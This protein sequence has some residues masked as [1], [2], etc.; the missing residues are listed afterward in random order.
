MA[1]SAARTFLRVPLQTQPPFALARWLNE[2]SPLS[3]LSADV[4]ALAE[5]ALADAEAIASL[6]DQVPDVLAA[7]SRHEAQPPPDT[8]EAELHAGVRSRV[9]GCRLCCGHCV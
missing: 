6:A 3:Q 5:A 2:R 9:L 8:L 7:I 4:K 1:R